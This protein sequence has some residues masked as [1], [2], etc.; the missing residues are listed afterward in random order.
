LGLQGCN[1]LTRLHNYLHVPLCALFMYGA[2]DFMNVMLHTLFCYV[3]AYK[4]M[5]LVCCCYLFSSL[6]AVQHVA[7]FEQ[8]CHSI[9][10]VHELGLLLALKATGSGCILSAASPVK[11]WLLHASNSALWHYEWGT[12]IS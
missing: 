12:N 7:C 3:V 10:C 1:Q 8:H 9:G 5:H 2:P 6:G 4:H 11:L